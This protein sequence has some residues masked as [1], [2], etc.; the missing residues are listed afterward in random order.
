MV[1]DKDCRPIR[2]A[3]DNPMLDTQL[4]QV[5][6][7]DGH[8]E[9]FAA[10]VIAENMFAQ[11]DKNGHRQVLLDE[12]IKHCKDGCAVSIDDTFITS[13]NGVKQQQETTIGWELL[14][15]WKDGSTSW[16]PLISKRRHQ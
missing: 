14:I 5:E 11:I 9:T 2:T 1:E 12:I 6:F 15:Q 7:A 13:H 3:H 16:I 8:S 10:N 4:Y